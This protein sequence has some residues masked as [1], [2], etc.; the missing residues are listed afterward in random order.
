MSTEISSAELRSLREAAGL[1]RVVLARRMSL[2]A[3]QLSQ[4]E[5]GQDS[6]FYSPAIRQGAAL[7]V[8]RY[9]QAQLQSPAAERKA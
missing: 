9:L 4:L 8:Y 6:L 2:S 1:D 7:K 5:C 3:A